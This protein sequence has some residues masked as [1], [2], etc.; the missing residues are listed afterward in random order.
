MAKF[1]SDGFLILRTWKFLKQFRFFVRHKCTLHSVQKQCVFWLHRSP[2][3]RLAFRFPSISGQWFIPL[4]RRSFSGLFSVLARLVDGFSFFRTTFLLISVAVTI[5]GV[6]CSPIEMIFFPLHG[7]DVHC[8][9]EEYIL[10]VDAALCLAEFSLK[11]NS[12]LNN[13]KLWYIKNIYKRKY[14]LSLIHLTKKKNEISHRIRALYRFNLEML[15]STDKSCC[16]LSCLLDR[17][18]IW[19]L[20][21]LNSPMRSPIDSK[22]FIWN[23]LGPAQIS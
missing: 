3:Q 18:N 13:Y 8:W 12:H 22:S 11:G 16:I 10:F 6:L 23:W 14:L 1:V 17:N 2:L 15:D 5:W 7:R 9:T 19:L 20:P 21:S 4:Y